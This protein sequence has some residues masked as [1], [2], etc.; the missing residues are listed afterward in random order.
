MVE[1]Q[2]L[3]GSGKKP[4]QTGFFFK[5]RQHQQHRNRIHLVRSECKTVC[6]GCYIQDV[7]RIF[8]LPTSYSR[9]IDVLRLPV[10]TRFVPILTTRMTVG[11]FCQEQWVCI[12]KNTAQYPTRPSYMY[13]LYYSLGSGNFGETLTTLFEQL[14]NLQKECQHL[15]SDCIHVKSRSW[16][17]V[18]MY[19]WFTS[20]NRNSQLLV[21]QSTNIKLCISR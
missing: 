10:T 8:V 18:D 19:V 2:I 13:R 16:Q 14:Q 3:W 17:R 20:S 15:F 6:I 11:S 4:G 1:N 12:N 5:E 7:E 9:V 21:G